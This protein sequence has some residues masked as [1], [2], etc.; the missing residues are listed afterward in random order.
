MNLRKYIAELKRRNVVK[1]GIAYLIVAWVIVQVAEIVLPTFDVPAYVMKTLLII[2]GIGFPIS[3]VLAW[4]FELT[5]EGIKKSVDVDKEK[6]TAY[7]TK[8]WLNRLII[9]SLSILVILLLVNQFWFEQSEKD[10]NIGDKTQATRIIGVL[11]FS[12]SKPDSK[13]DYFGFAIADQIIG[14]LAYL[15]NITVRPSSSIRK[16]EKQV[17]DSKT[18]AE[19]LNVA[20]IL[21]GNFLMEGNIIRLNV[22]LVEV[23]VNKMIWRDQIEVEFKNAFDLQ[24]IVAKKVAESVNAEFSKQ[25]KSR[26]N[27]DIPSNPL[28]YEYYLRGIAL[29]LTIEDNQIAVEILQKSIELDS[30][31]APAYSALADRLHRVALYGNYD[32]EKN[33]EVEEIYLKAI[34]LNKDL[35][36]ANTGLAMYYTETA[37]IYEAVEI[38]NHV[39][40][41]NPNNADA[42]FSLGYI[43]RYAGMVNE[44]ISVMEMTP[45]IRHFD[46]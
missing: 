27:K 20:F 4:I 22:E 2:L 18:A 39:L 28:A 17:I 30:S 33:N 45:V 46:L 43:Y 44:S 36:S 3:L 13:T 31:F 23:N 6:T 29:P 38:S 25:E 41:I 40:E 26:I 37:R 8:N 11:P 5:P 9:G 34:S 42:L 21:A 24:D 15:K 10:I 14:D 35:I 19:E 32:S 12:N 16:Y 7:R 1:E